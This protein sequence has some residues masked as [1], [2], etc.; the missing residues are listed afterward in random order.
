MFLFEDKTGI[1]IDNLEIEWY[2]VSSRGKALKLTAAE[3][4]PCLTG[5]F[6]G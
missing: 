1:G 5:Y 3:H 2:R 4:N 6:G